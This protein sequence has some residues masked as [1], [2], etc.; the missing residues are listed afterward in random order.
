MA[1]I[2]K[3]LGGEMD[4]ATIDAGMG[5]DAALGGLQARGYTP[6]VVYD[7]GAADG[8]WTRQAMRYWPD[9]HYVCFEPLEERKEEL[10]NLQRSASHSDQIVLQHC[11]VGDTD[12]ELSM[13]VTD[14]LWD[15][16]FAYS[17]SSSRMVPVHRLDTL[18]E[19]GMALPSFIKIDVQGFEKRVLDGGAKAME[20]ADLILMECAFF[21]FC[22]DMRTLDV[23]IAYMSERGFIPYEFVD[24]LRRPLDGA[25]GQCDILF[26]RR[27][28]WLVSTHRWA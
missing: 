28:H 12:G 20:H 10:R 8:S 7:I 19:E 11:G 17:G 22:H 23:S 14:F 3:L 9:A 2:K 26:V 18:I 21:P 25:M 24:Y 13:G 5:M 4:K 16:S 6:D 15:S 1:W 27:D